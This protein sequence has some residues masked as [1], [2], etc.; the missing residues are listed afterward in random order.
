MSSGVPIYQT[1]LCMHIYVFYIHVSYFFVIYRDKH[2][3]KLK[4]LV[5]DIYTTIHSAAA[6]VTAA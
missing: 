6:I 4:C 3:C 2:T 1:M 5:S